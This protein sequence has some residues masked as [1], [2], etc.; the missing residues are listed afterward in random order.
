MSTPK[1]KKTGE[2]K[3]LRLYNFLLKKLGEANK[4]QPKKQLLG[5]ETRRKIVKE[6]LFPFFKG[7]P[8]LSIREINSYAK[9]VIENL[10]PSEIC[11]PLYLSEA[12]L[13]DVEYYEIDNHIRTILPDCLDLRVNAGA[14][15][16]TKIFNTSS[17]S[18]YS[19]G[20]RKIVEAIRDYMASNA[21]GEAY[22]NGVVKLKYKKPN[23]GKAENYFVDY[24]LFINNETEIDDTPVN[25]NLPKKEQKKV[26][27]I[28][29]TLAQRLKTLQKE[30]RKR[31]RVAK[32]AQPKKPQQKK[33]EAQ[34]A[35]K[36]AV[37][38]LR[39]L[40]QNGTITKDEYN[41]QKSILEKFKKRP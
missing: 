5:I 7:K 29:D 3:G 12:Y 17:Y 33:K 19:D 18:Y 22:F 9:K 20:V 38:A 21:S 24:V 27:K 6:Q 10:P 30:K 31:K 26:E 37:A 23:N 39:K 15:G 25:F 13:G 16:K 14:L 1:K 8:K 32:K 34:E 40:Y 4:K 36:S 28:R 11:N 35:I 41:T 2:L